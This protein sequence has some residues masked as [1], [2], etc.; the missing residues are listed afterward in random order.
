MQEFVDSTNDIIW[1]PALIC[2]CAGT[3]LFSSILT[4]YVQVQVLR[5][6]PAL[7]F[8]GLRTDPVPES[9]PARI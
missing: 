5:E 6:M 9:A 2:L 3:A 4:R 7:L 8:S 1:S